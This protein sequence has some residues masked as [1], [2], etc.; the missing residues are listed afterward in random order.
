[1]RML[2]YLLNDRD[3]LCVRRTPLTPEEWNCASSEEHGHAYGFAYRAET[4]KKQRQVVC[5]PHTEY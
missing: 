5:M 2:C 1:M 4:N 3:V